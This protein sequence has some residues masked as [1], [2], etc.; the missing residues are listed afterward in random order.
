MANDTPVW[1]VE[2]QMRLFEHPSTSLRLLMRDTVESDAAMMSRTLFAAAHGTVLFGVEERMI[3]VPRTL[4][5]ESIENFVRLNCDGL[6]RR[7]HS[8]KGEG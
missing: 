7:S 5:E 4:I 2:E 8:R 3:S 6:L 1:F